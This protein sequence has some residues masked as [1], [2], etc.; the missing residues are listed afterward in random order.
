[1]AHRGKPSTIGSIVNLFTGT[2]G[3]SPAFV[4]CH[5]VEVEGSNHD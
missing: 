1:M 2:A 3:V 5:F 4:E